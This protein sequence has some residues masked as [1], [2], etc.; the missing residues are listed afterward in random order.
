[1]RTIHLR[2]K[3]GKNGSL[4]LDIPVGMAETECDVFVVV[5][6]QPPAQWLPGFWEQLSRGWQGEV[7]QRPAQGQYD[8]RTPWR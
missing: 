5:A 2:E 7:L 8:A 6:P 3:T 4:H 1:M